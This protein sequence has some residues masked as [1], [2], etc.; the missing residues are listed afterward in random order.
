[1]FRV[2][3]ERERERERQ[4]KGGR[5]RDRGQAECE[6]YNWKEARYSEV[7]RRVERVEITRVAGNLSR[8]SELNTKEPDLD[9]R[10]GS[11]GARAPRNSIIFGQNAST[12]D[13]RA[14]C[15]C[16]RPLYVPAACFV[17]RP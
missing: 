16:M 4:I 5:A 12:A 13:G 17:Q 10:A 6:R 2:R 9:R 7:T 14:A 8:A 11:T 3:R 1:M 15:V